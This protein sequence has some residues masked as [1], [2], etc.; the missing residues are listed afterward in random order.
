M[1]KRRP[2]YYLLP[3]QA[4]DSLGLI[5]KTDFSAR[6]RT[7]FASCDKHIVVGDGPDNI[8]GYCPVCF[9]KSTDLAIN[10][11]A[12]EGRDEYGIVHLTIPTTAIQRANC[13]RSIKVGNKLIG[14]KSYCPIC[15]DR[16]VIEDLPVPEKSIKRR[17][18]EHHFEKPEIIFSDPDLD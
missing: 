3:N 10:L 12:D 16:E 11:A 14:I 5:H 9:G 4:R 7:R 6:L 1:T 18:I 2:K 8:K 17:N 13:N 15:Y